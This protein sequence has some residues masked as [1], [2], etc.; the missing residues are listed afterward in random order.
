M[1]EE[2]EEEGEGEGEGASALQNVKEK[3]LEKKKSGRSWL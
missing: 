1:R 2:E 3:K